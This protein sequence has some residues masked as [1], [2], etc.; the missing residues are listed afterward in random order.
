[1][2]AAR[3]PASYSS[4]DQTAPKPGQTM[5][6]ATFNLE[7]VFVSHAKLAWEKSYPVQLENLK[8]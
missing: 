2:F 6:A 3:K 5:R 4:G 1:M 7:C 8:A